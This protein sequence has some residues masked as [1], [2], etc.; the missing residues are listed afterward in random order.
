M[1]QSQIMEQEESNSLKDF[2]WGLTDKKSR[3]IK[4]TGEDRN[5]SRKLKSKLVVNRRNI[6]LTETVMFCKVK[7]LRSVL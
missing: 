6:L 4:E 5:A 2:K 3:E 7:V 1:K